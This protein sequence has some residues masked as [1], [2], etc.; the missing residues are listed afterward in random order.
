MN[1]EDALAPES[2]LFDRL[3]VGRLPILPAVKNA[4]DHDRVLLDQVHN[5]V[6]SLAVRHDKLS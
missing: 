5:D 1:G 3:G 4:K 2:L 6:G